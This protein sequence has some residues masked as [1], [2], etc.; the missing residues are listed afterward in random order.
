MRNCFL[1]KLQ[2]DNNLINFVFFVGSES[3][4]ILI[5]L[6][7]TIKNKNNKGNFNRIT[8]YDK[9]HYCYTNKKIQ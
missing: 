1:N 2:P 7:T 5:G 6:Q 9:K 8:K 4:A 3:K